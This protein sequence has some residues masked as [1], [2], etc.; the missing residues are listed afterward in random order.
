MD[1]DRV[2]REKREMIERLLSLAGHT[3]AQVS[4]IIKKYPASIGGAD[5]LTSVPDKQL[6]AAIGSLEHFSH[7]LAQCEELGINPWDDQEFLRLCLKQLGYTVSSEYLKNITSD[8]LVEGYN[9][10]NVQVYRNMKFMEICGYSLEDVL[11]YPWPNLYERSQQITNKI[12]ARVRESLESGR[13]LKA[14]VETH[15]MKEHA[16]ST[17]QIVEV[18]FRYIAPLYRNPGQPSG[19]LISSQA[20]MLEEYPSRHEL[21]FL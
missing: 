17:R 9:L 8:D 15:Y 12:L 16:S 6:H 19:Y 5:L 18:T 10:D 1:L 2:G 13:V 3:R 4:K 7:A 14:D 21:R 11:A 20:R